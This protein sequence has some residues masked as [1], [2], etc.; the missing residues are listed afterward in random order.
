MR[1]TLLLTK[2]TWTRGRRSR[3]QGRGPDPATFSD[4]NTVLLC[5]TASLLKEMLGDQIIFNVLS[6]GTDL[7]L[8]FPFKRKKECVSI[9]HLLGLCGGRWGNSISKPALF[10]LVSA[11]LFHV[12][13]GYLYK[14]TAS[15][16]Q[17]SRW[18]GIRI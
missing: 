16:A 6:C 14:R 5:L 4:G 2:M 13:L 12:P 15:A 8:N 3:L 7:Y 10:N 18:G 9:K 1:F 17:R 11:R